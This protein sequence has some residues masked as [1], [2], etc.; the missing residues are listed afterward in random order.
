[1]AYRKGKRSFS[2]RNS[3]SKKSYSKKSYSSKSHSKHL[4]CLYNPFSVD[5][6]QPKFPDGRTQYS[7]G[8]KHQATNE[9]QSGNFIV[10]LF[11]G[12]SNW[13]FAQSTTMTAAAA[14][15]PITGSASL[16][17]ASLRTMMNHNSTLSTVYS[18][19]TNATNWSVYPPLA[20]AFEAWRP[21]SYG[22]QIRC[23]NNDENNEG[24]YEAV[25]I[26]VNKL[27]LWETGLCTRIGTDTVDYNIGD[28]QIDPEILVDWLVQGKLAQNPTYTCGKF[29]DIGKYIFQLNHGNKDNDFISITDTSA[30]KVSS[31]DR[32]YGAITN[33]TNEA[34]GDITQ[35]IFPEK[36]LANENTARVGTFSTKNHV[37]SNMDIIVVKIVGE[38]NNTKALIHTVANHELTCKDGTDYAQY[39]SVAYSVLPQLQRFLDYRVKHHKLPLSLLKST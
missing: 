19:T 9:V 2:K 11:P 34:D 3:Y 25:R 16:K 24:W 35:F 30:T 22:M 8:R 4:A 5:S 17:Q 18:Y 33:A 12:F 20:N 28:I 1:M 32:Y 21:V 31:T 26:G 23:I 6:N 37:S 7:I 14:N 27:N 36:T 15:N 39:Q 10:V 29:K 38:A 13:C